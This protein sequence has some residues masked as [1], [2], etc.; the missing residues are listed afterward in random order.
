M[1]RKIRGR[2]QTLSLA[3]RMASCLLAELASMEDIMVVASQN[4]SFGGGAVDWDLSR[5]KESLQAGGCG[6]VTSRVF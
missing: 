3:E 4:L 2:A 5:T 1:G 6:W